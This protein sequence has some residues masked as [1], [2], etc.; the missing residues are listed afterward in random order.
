[1]VQQS[2]D[3]KVGCIRRG[4]LCANGVITLMSPVIS[5]MVDAVS[6]YAASGMSSLCSLRIWGR[7][8]EKDGRWSANEVM[9]I[10]VQT[11]VGGPH[12][13]SRVGIGAQ[14]SLR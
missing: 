1:M 14:I 4:L 5:I 11:I 9:K 8:Q 7:I 10:T 3:R 13:R 12:E 6:E 2:E